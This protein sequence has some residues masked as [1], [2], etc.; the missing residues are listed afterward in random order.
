MEDNDVLLFG[1]TSTQTGDG[2]PQ[3]SITDGVVKDMEQGFKANELVDKIL[4][5][6]HELRLTEV[7][8]ANLNTLCLM[9][10]TL[11][12]EVYEE[13]LERGLV[14]PK[15]EETLHLTLKFKWYDMIASG[16]KKEEYRNLTEHWAKQ[17][18]PTDNP[19]NNMKPYVCFHRGYTNT[20]MVFRIDSVTIGKGKPEWMESEDR[21]KEVF[22]IKLGGRVK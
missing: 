9:A 11:K 20:T 14:M 19:F 7:S 22:I 10:N 16:I 5:E 2:K 12:E 15:P 8:D 18:E 17:I 6:F 3:E 1:L 13:Q 4:G 21:D